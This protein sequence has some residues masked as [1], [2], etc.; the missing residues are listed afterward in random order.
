M[1]LAERKRKGLRVTGAH[2]PGHGKAKTR[3]EGIPEIKRVGEAGLG[4][5]R[6]RGTKPPP[7]PVAKRR[8]TR[9][10]KVAAKKVPWY[11]R[12]AKAFKEA[13]AEA[14]SQAQTDQKPSGKYGTK[15]QAQQ[16]RE[17]AKKTVPKFKEK[18]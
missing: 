7:P 11:M 9:K 12:A 18:K 15:K 4:E 17:A 1:S 13:G 16:I 5:F 8:P 14:L 10:K 6:G 2:V 3:G